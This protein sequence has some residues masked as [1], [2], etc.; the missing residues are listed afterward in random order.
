V[1]GFLLDA[2]VPIAVADGVRDL[3]P[4]CLIEHLARWRDGMYRNAVDEDILVAARAARLV[5]VTYDRD[6]IPSIV[7]RWLAEGRS[8]PGLALISSRT[9]G[10]NDVGSVVRAI[11]RL[12]DAPAL[13]GSAYPIV[14]LRPPP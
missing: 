8:V 9:A 4:D 14:Y 13:L 1:Q 2:H 6:T 7:H 5:L 12:Y 11:V 10:Q 3:R